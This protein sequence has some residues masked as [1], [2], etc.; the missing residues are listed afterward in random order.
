MSPGAH[1]DIGYEI[2]GTR[3]MLRYSYDNINDL[4][5]YRGEGPKI[6]AA[7]SALPPDPAI[8]CTLRCSRPPDLRL[9]TT[10]SRRSRREN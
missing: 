10:I 5:L 8:R 6:F 7:L 3:G 2:I 1:F 4:Y 9:A